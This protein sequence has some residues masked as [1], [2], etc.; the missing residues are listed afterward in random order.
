MPLTAEQ[1]DAFAFSSPNAYFN[2]LD[3]HRLPVLR[4]DLLHHA[5][6]CYTAVMEAKRLNRLA[7]TRLMAA[8]KYAELARGLGLSLP[9]EPLEPAWRNVLFN[10]FHDILGGCSLRAAYEDARESF[11][12]SLN[13]A[14]R[15]TNCSLQAIAWNIDTSQGLP[16]RNNK[17]DFRL[18]E[19]EGRGVPV[20]VF[21]PHDRAAILPVRTGVQVASVADEAGQ[22]VPCQRLR[23]PVTNGREDKWET[24]FLAEV[25]PLGWRTYWLY[26]NP[27]ATAARS[28][29]MLE[30]GPDRLE[31]DWLAVRL[32]PNS[33][34][35][36]SLYDK[37]AGKHLLTGEASALVI[38]ET[39]CDTWAHR[40][41][42]FRDVVGRFEGARPTLM[43][44]GDVQAAVHVAGRYE[45]S[46]LEQRITLYRD[47]PGLFIEYR[48]QWNQP[49]QMLKLDFPTPWK[50]GRVTA[51]IPYGHWERPA[52]GKE[53]PMQRWVL[54]HS[55]GYGLGVATDSRSAYDALEGG[56]RIT[57]LRSPLYADHFGERDAYTEFTE[58]GEQRFALM[59]APVDGD[60]APFA[61]AATELGTPV[62][63]IVGT[64][65]KGS[66]PQVGQALRVSA[67]NIRVAVF[68]RS[69]EGDGLILRC[70][71]TAGRACEAHIEL[72][73]HGYAWTA[74]FTPQQIRSFLLR[75]GEVVPVNL[76]EEV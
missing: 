60:I 21:N 38:D 6:G 12:E 18:W 43:E 59:L 65:H 8:E 72:P 31:N 39:A 19:Q 23:G 17:H 64:Y 3:E 51:S 20:T 55:D 33:G 71:E 56:L 1:P 57:A 62:E 40:V 63:R 52:D 15:V 30:A 34:R 54:L 9:D 10:Q 37:V 75:D 66:L 25:P 41:F 27:K 49:H 68:K 53:Q 47:K 36:R 76:L 5:S 22:S 74:A 46:I 45:S 67:P 42:A 69:E 13:V 58:Q 4:D 73:L 26:Q 14:A 48:V 50:E 29:R 24:A 70:H 11:G 32:D 61:A 35:I 2:E 28:S 7:E 44:C 16:V